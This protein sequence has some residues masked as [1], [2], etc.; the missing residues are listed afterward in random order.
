MTALLEYLDL[1]IARLNNRQKLLVLLLL[2]LTV[3]HLRYFNYHMLRCVSI[4]KLL[5]MFEMEFFSAKPSDPML[6]L[7]FYQGSCLGCLNG[8]YATALQ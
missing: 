3:E 6:S 8:S 7:K 1:F 4:A 2:F 5:V